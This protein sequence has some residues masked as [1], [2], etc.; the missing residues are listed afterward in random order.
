MAV[1]PQ[2]PQTQF[3]L[4]F[5]KKNMGF[6]WEKRGN[7]GYLIPNL[8]QTD[9]QAEL[10]DRSHWDMKSVV[11]CEDRGTCTCSMSMTS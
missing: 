11:I 2:V 6:P 9:H 7:L 3:T 10:N 8:L 4:L 1:T 5:L